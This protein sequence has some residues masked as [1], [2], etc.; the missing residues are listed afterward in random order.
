MDGVGEIPDILALA[1]DCQTF[2][3]L[4]LAGG[5]LDQPAGLC[6]KMRIYLNVHKALIAWKHIRPNRIKEFKNDYPDAWAIVKEY[7]RG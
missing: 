2:S 4:P 1:F 5:V 3:A 6:K 7:L